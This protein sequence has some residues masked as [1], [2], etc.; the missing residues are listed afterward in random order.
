MLPKKRTIWRGSMI[1]A[2]GLA[3]VFIASAATA[4]DRHRGERINHQLDFLAL[5]AAL[6]GDPYLA[7]TLDHKGDRIEHR[8]DHR[9]HR[10]HD[11]HGSTHWRRPFSKHHRHFDGCGHGSIGHRSWRRSHHDRHLDRHKRRHQKRHH[12]RHHM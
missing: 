1:A 6:S 7:M 12:W 5:I 11:D 10:R 3:T 4:N 2:V 8:Y 9:R